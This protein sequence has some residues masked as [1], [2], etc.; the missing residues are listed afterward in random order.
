VI[1]DA[2]VGTA[3]DAAVALELGCDAV[4]MNTAI[5]EAKDPILMAEAMR[6]GVEAGRKAYLAGRMPKKLYASAS[7]PMDGRIE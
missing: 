5:A 3:S 4:L 2:G 6:L 7:S 1:V